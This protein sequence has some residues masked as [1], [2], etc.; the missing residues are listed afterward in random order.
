M[1]TSQKKPVASS[2]DI[3]SVRKL[4]VLAGGGALPARLAACCEKQGIEIFIVA[5]D[6]QTY[7]ETVQNREHI[8]TTLGSAGKIIKTLKSHN[9]SDLVMIGHIRRPAFSELKPDLKGA[10]ILAR[11]G[12]KSLGDN[13]LLELLRGEL[14]REGFRLHGIQQFVADLLTKEGILGRY[15][16]SQKNLESIKRGISVAQALGKQDVGQSVIVQNGLIIA[17]EAIEGTDEMIH[18]SKGYL[19]AGGG[20]ILVKSCKPHQDKDLDLPTIGPD[21]VRA[22]IDA[23]LVG[24]AIE[25]R[26]SL[27][28]DADELV[29]FA[30]QHKIFVYGFST[31]D[32]GI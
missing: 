27:M 3:A 15:K 6:G 18:R 4:G 23:G 21:T 25:A 17:V 30:N 13:D 11:I 16:P 19:R 26:N 1:P 28:V 31:K 5:F 12:M 29:G 7:P 20:A 9:V 2:S 22:A 8:W 10:E 24:I 14:E 32:Y